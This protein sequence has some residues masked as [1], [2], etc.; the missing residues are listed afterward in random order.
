MIWVLLDALRFGM[1]EI[2]GDWRVVYANATAMQVLR[3]ADALSTAN[4]RIEFRRRKDRE[5][6][7]EWLRHS[8]AERESVP[9]VLPRLSGRLSYVIHRI[10]AE[11]RETP[12]E[13]RHA[14][15]LIDPE[16]SSPV[17]PGVLVEVFGLTRAEASLAA[18][19]AVGAS[20][21]ELAARAGIAEGTV[22]RHLERIFLKTGSERQVD[23]VRK[24]LAC[25]APLS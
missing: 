22:R 3:D 23:L 12:A 13:L 10:T 14:L 25:A 5:R 24:V 6:A 4:G 1:L 16:R 17:E 21:Q 8:A 7:A 19:L 15:L 9:L 20:V 18:A 2:D 11:A